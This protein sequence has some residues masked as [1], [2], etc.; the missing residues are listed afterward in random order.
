MTR[1]NR[2][3]AIG[4]GAGL[5]ASSAVPA[6]ARSVDPD[7]AQTYLEQARRVIAASS[8]LGEPFAPADV[9]EIERL[10][11]GGA[12]ASAVHAAH[13]LFDRHVLL[14]ATVSPEARVSVRQGPAAPQLAQSGWRIFLVRI[15]NPQI[16]PGRVDVTSP[17]GKPA[18]NRYPAG[19]RHAAPEGQEDHS[20]ITAGDLIERW[21]DINVHDEAPLPATLD[22][23]PV[24]YRVIALYARDAGRRSA[25]LFVDVGPGTGDIGERG[26][27]SVTFQIVPARIVS[28]GIRDADGAPVT[29]SLLIRDGEGRVYPAQTKRVLPDLYFQ[30]KVY[31]ADGETLTL[32]PGEYRV[33]SARGPEYVLGRSTRAVA[34]NGAVRW[35]VKLERWIDPRDHGYYSGDHHIHAAG[36]SHYDVPEEGV[37]PSVMIPQVAGEAINIGAVLTWGPGFYTQKLNFSGHD[38][39]VSRPQHGL[40]YDLEVSGFPSSHCGHLVL[41]Q[42]KGMDYPGTTKIEQWPTSNTPV[43]EWARSQGAITGYA[44]S[45]FGLWADTTDLPNYKMPAFDSIGAND[46]IVTVT[47]GLVDFISTVSSMPAAELNIWYHTLNAGYRTRIAGETDWPCIYDENMGI[48]RS[49]VKLTGPLSYQGWCEG[50]K[51]GRSYVSEGRAHIIDFSVRGGDRTTTPGGTDLAVANPV[52]LTISARVAARL[53]PEI[54]PATEAIRAAG[55][56]DKP[57]WH[58]ERARIGTTRKVMVELIVNGVPVESRPFDADGVQ[59]DLAFDFVPAA[60]CWIA[61]R[62]AH[63][64]HSNPVWVTIGGKPMRIARSIAWCRAAV[65]QCWSQK[66]LRIRAPEL[67]A[68][69]ARYDA[70]RAIYDARAK[71]VAT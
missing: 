2:R 17:Q 45:G 24:D 7:L 20:A 71:E 25:R 12:T 64:A 10:A 52:P 61:L 38:D 11:A 51:A 55:P 18:N 44:H 39:P 35:P 29:C 8:K 1:I 70:A 40:H 4:T 27:A 46:Y 53:E 48:G 32:P 50:L 36:C 59:R 54:T 3:A 22:P 62:I 56:Q 15:D 5:L 68:E 13:S 63:G 60:T 47:A 9:A 31:R 41:L 69:A 43:L 14:I 49:Y 23:V 21:L 57:Y 33:E 6:L 26:Y 65:D 42:M 28:L 30:R 16:V 37:P 67:A 34:A 66:K 19:H 58:L